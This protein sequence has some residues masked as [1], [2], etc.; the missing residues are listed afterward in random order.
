MKYEI[1]A[2]PAFSVIGKLGS[3]EEGEGFIGRLWADANA[4]FS[5]I[6]HLAKMNAD[7]SLTGFWGAMS[8]VSMAFLPWED[9]FSKGYYL[10]GVEAADENEPPCGWVKWRVPGFEYMKLEN[11]APDAFSRMIGYM[12]AQGIGLQGAVQELNDPV[13]GRGYLLFPVKRLEKQ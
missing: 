10:A 9:G 12:Q 1:I 7:G 11:D 13:S 4:H 6:A 2:K 5:E 3:T 8:D